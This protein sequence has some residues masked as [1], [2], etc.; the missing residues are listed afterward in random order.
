M[1]ASTL[2]VDN[3]PWD[4][5][6]ELPSRLDLDDVDASWSSIDGAPSD[7]WR[8]LG[9]IRRKQLLDEDRRKGRQ[10][11]DLNIHC[12]VDRYFQ[13]AHRVS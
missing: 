12:Q 6:I 13:V 9:Q 3:I 4:E 1:T 11:F 10:S 8:K 2:D 5:A 7:D